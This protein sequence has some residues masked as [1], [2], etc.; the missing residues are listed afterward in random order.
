MILAEFIGRI[1]GWGMFIVLRTDPSELAIRTGLLL[2]V[3]S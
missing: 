3:I 2:S 1:I